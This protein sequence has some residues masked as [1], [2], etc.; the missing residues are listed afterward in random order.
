[1]Y[2]F[3]K[4]SKMNMSGIDDRLIT[5]LERSILKSPYDFGIPKYGGY[6]SVQ[7]QQ[8]LYSLGRETNGLIVTW[9]D[10]VN[11]K[12]YHQS[13]NAFDIYLYDEHGACWSCVDKYHV[14]SSVILTEFAVMKQNG[15]FLDNE[16]LGWGGN[17]EGKKK[18]LP[19]FQLVVKE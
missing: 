19:H 13:G 7:D 12:S 9:A 15:E 10:G 11:K 2:K 16:Y 8:Y 14:I 1:M 6:R 4:S 18:D 5:L 3:S 17:W